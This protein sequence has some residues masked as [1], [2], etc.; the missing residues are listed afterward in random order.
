MPFKY[1]AVK[2]ASETNSVI[3]PF[4][5]TKKYRLLN[6]SITI[7]FGE[8]YKVTGNIKEDNKILEEKVSKLIRSNTWKKN[9]KKDIN[10]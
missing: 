7:C 3:V 9:I 4:S 1:G 6:K 5:I 8:A 2:M 10:S